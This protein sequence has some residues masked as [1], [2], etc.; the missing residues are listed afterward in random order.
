MKTVRSTAIVAALFLASIIL[1]GCAQFQAL[2]TSLGNSLGIGTPT[3]TTIIG[4]T[5]AEKADQLLSLFDSTVK[6]L[7]ALTASGQI[8]PATHEMLNPAV[9]AANAAVLGII[10]EVTSSPADTAAFETALANAAAAVDKLVVA[11][12]SATVASTPVAKS[13]ATK[14]S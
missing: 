2:G 14:P 13:A 10:A 8:S 6:E 1:P 7:N 12:L 11:K 9:Q 3:G 5:P 4:Q